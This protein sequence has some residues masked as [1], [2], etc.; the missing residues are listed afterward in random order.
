[1]VDTVK[2]PAY[3]GKRQRVRVNEVAAFPTRLKFLFEIEERAILSWIAEMLCQEINTRVQEGAM[4]AIDIAH[5]SKAETH[6]SGAGHAQMFDGACQQAFHGA[7]SGLIGAAHEVKPP[8]VTPINRHKGHKGMYPV[9]LINSEGIDLFIVAI[10]IETA[11][12]ESHL[13]AT[14]AREPAT[15]DLFHLCQLI[16]ISYQ[17][18]P[19]NDANA[20]FFSALCACAHIGHSFSGEGKRASCD[21]GILTNF[22]HMQFGRAIQVNMSIAYLPEDDRPILLLAERH[23]LLDGRKQL[24]LWS[25]GV[26]CNDGDIALKNVADDR[27]TGGAEEV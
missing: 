13:S 1:M 9:A 14:L 24:L 20:L 16:N 23:K 4:S 19:E 17:P 6:D 25:N 11:H 2:C 27:F 10:R 21:D 8:A 12:T 5:R 26:A 7:G 15:R 18:M 3:F 22:Q